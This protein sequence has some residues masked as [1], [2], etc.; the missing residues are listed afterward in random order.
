[1]SDWKSLL[2]M[3]LLAKGLRGTAFA[4][5]SLLAQGTAHAGTPIEPII[6]RARER[7]GEVRQASPSLEQLIMQQRG[8]SHVIGGHRSHSS[9]SSHRSHSSHSSH[10][11]SRGGGSYYP[12]S[13]PPS[14]PRPSPTPPSPPPSSGGTAQGTI[15]KVTLNNGRIYRGTVVQT[16]TELVITTAKQSVIRVLRSDVKSIVVEDA[17]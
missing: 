6:I 12:P 14:V 9:H 8:E 16:D 3:R 13:P 2:K 17:P 1:M 7:S 15:Y 11:S 5:A 10:Y 4:A